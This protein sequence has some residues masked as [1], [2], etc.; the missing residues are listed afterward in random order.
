MRI[1]EI[2]MKNFGKFSDRR[3]CFHEGVNI[4]YG[5]NEAGKSTV[6]AFLR[7]MLFGIERARGRRAGNDEYS[8]R[9]PWE[10]PGYFAG[11]M[12]FESGGKVFRLERNFNRREKSVSLVCET[13][14]EELSVESGDLDVLLEGLN[15]TSYRN[16]FLWG[17][18]E[19]LRERDWRR[20]CI[21][22]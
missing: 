1:L 9:K 16:T 8:L 11:V 17:R 20:S 6:H 12:R 3:I 15:E 22:I 21:I 10:N 5:K 18:Q 19:P 14:G 2:Q 13:D 7:A 4:L